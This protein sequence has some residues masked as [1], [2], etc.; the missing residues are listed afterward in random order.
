MSRSQGLGIGEADLEWSPQKKEEVAGTAQLP[1]PPLEEQPKH[2][3]LRRRRQQGLDQL[4]IVADLLQATGQQP[5]ANPHGGSGLRSPAVVTV[6]THTPASIQECCDCGTQCG[7]VGILEQAL[8][9]QAENG[10][11]V[12]RKRGRQQQEQGGGLPVLTQTS[13][14][15]IKKGEVFNPPDRPD[16]EARVTDQVVVP[17]PDHQLRITG[18]EAQGQGFTQQGRRQQKNLSFGSVQQAPARSFRPS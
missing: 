10:L 11:G 5:L 15:L 18:C 16:H 4:K 12:D 6:K 13:Q 7:G 14:F 9:I 1:R 2:Q 3:V 17:Q 8:A